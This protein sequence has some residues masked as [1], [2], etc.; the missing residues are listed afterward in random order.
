M[1]IIKNLRSRVGSIRDSLLDMV[2][3]IQLDYKFSEEIARHLEGVRLRAGHKSLVDL[4]KRAF[5][6]YDFA[7]EV[8]LEGD[9]I[10]LKDKI[11]I[12]E[13]V[14]LFPVEPLDFKLESSETRDYNSNVQL[15]VHVPRRLLK[16]IHLLSQRSEKSRS[17]VLRHALALYDTVTEAVYCSGCTVEIEDSKG[18]ITT[19]TII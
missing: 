14:D 17:E 5:A 2:S 16:A 6:L 9:K 8:V 18:E 11:G 12:R 4:I 1:N 13:G 15:T 7:T 10:F 3:P 19:L